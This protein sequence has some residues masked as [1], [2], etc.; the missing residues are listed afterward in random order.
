MSTLSTLLKL[1]IST[2]ETLTGDDLSGPSPLLH[3]GYD[4]NRTMDASTTPDNT[5]A[6]YQTFAMSGGLKTIDL[7]NLLLD[8]AVVNLNL[9]KP[10]ALL[11]TALATN[12]GTTTIVKGASNGYDGLGAAF[13]IALEPGMS[14]AV[15][16]STQG[17]AVGASNKTLDMSG[18]GT[19]AVRF[20]VC[21]G[22]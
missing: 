5:A 13:S 6:A 4:V 12:A 10:R 18:T 7:T 22:T 8:A 20:S 1:N 16:F 19:D 9:K 15:D 2:T 17:N 21:A 14:V 3:S 11:M